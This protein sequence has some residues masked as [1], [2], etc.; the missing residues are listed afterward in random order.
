MLKHEDLKLAELPEEV[1]TPW[2]LDS[3]LRSTI[4]GITY[5]KSDYSS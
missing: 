3:N 1:Q 5:S 4:L 2:L